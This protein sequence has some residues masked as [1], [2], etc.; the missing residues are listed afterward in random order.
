MVAGE[1]GCRL[2]VGWGLQ[3]SR[4]GGVQLRE[5]RGGGVWAAGEMGWEFEV[6]RWWPG[7]W[8]AGCGRDGLG[9]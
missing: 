1:A 7:R 5:S 9:V 3:E 8:G 4:G 2:E 6:S